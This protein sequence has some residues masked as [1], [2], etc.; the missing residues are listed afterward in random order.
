MIIFAL[1]AYLLMGTFFMGMLPDSAG[2]TFGVMV[3]LWPIIVPILAI[4][5]LFNIVFELGDKISRKF[6]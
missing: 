3:I 1:I 5:K 4:A 6:R 2:N